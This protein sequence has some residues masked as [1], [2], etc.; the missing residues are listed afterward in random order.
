M[1]LLLHDTTSVHTRNVAVVAAL[2][3]SVNHVK[4][5]TLQSRH[6]SV[7]ILFNP[8]NG[9]NEIQGETYTGDEEVSK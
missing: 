5:L 4:L 2:L 6:V 1:V 9:K 7:G 8:K 3:I